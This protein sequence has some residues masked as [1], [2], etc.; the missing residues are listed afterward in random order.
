MDLTTLPIM[1]DLNTHYFGHRQRVKNKFLKS[2]PETLE[3]Y[4]LLE[5]L[6]FGAV[7]RKDVKPIAKKLLQEFGDLKA[8]INCDI[9]SLLQVADTNQSM[10]IIFAA[11]KELYRRVILHNN[12]KEKNILN[13]W[14]A[15]VDYLKMHMG[16]NTTE[17]FRV[18]FL[19]KKNILIADEIQSNGT[20]DQ[21]AIY[22]REIIRKCL[23]YGAGAVILVHNHPSGNPNPSQADIAL[24]K[25]IVQACEPL[26]IRVHD[27]L[28]IAQNRIFSFKS[29]LLL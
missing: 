26:D 20:I 24:T 6:L 14:N 25:T 9:Y 10:Y 7:P 16:N 18:L 2:N 29:N 28:I 4:E 12:L 3:D 19:N 1:P 22:P 5:I 11:I 13:S 23:F 27:H 8:L 15:L 17:Q 21:A